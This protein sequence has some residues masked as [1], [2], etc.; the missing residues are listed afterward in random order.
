MKFLDVNEDEGK[1]VVSQKRATAGAN[2][3]DLK[4]GEVIAGT[5]TGLRPYGAFLELEGGCAGLLHISQISYDR[6]D[7]LEALFTI[8]QKCKVC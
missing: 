7:N 4:R 3:S 5:I 8:G 1:L 2:P 6:I